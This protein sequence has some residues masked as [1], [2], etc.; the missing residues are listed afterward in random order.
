MRRWILKK[1]KKKDSRYLF[2][3]S[4]YFLL[5]LFLPMEPKNSCKKSKHDKLTAVERMGGEREGEGKS[6]NG[7][8]GNMQ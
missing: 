8:N 6:T 7:R 4:F 1:K 5:L 2:V 3:I